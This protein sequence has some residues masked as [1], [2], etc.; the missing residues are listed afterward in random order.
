MTTGHHI[1]PNIVSDYQEEKEDPN[2]ARL[3]VGGDKIKSPLDCGTPTEDIFTKK[4]LLNS[5]VLT[6][7]AKF[8]TL[9]I[10]NFYLNTPMGRFEYMR[11]KIEDIPKN[12][13][14]KYEL[15]AK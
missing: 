8:F 4:L 12:L 3:V 7:R 9:D 11:L 1:W 2:R 10:K 13:I 6:N 15:R 5:V 14:E